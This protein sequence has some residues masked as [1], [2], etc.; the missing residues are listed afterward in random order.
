[1]LNAIDFVT[2]YLKIIIKENINLV[3]VKNIDMSPIVG[4]PRLGHLVTIL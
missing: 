4:R 1:M 3:R 2:G